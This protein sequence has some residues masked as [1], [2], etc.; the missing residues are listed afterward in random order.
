MGSPSLQKKKELHYRRGPTSRA[1]SDCNHFIWLGSDTERDGRCKIMGL[2]PGRAYR[3]NPD[4]I[5]DAHDN[6]EYLK[7]LREGTRFAE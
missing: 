2:E 4:N 6:S 1:C 7:R 3:I 5:C